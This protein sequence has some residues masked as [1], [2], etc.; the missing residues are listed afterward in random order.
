MSL[1]WILVAS[2]IGIIVLSIVVFVLIR[3]NAR[4]KEEKILERIYGSH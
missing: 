2:G 3:A 4:K 1:G